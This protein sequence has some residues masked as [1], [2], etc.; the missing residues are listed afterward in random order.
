MI[1]LYDELSAKVDNGSDRA[2]RDGA[3]RDLGL[4]LFAEREAI[5]D[6]WKE[7]ELL[8]YCARMSRQKA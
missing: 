7:A 8:S 5:R 3:R 1:S 2:R 6:L 4:L